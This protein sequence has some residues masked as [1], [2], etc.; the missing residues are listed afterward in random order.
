MRYSDKLEGGFRPDH[1]GMAE[2]LP[3]AL[4]LATCRD[5]SMTFNELAVTVS[6]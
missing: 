1:D 5:M 2:L 4:V 3:T 6:I